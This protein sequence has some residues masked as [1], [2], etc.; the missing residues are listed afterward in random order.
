M[1]D[2]LIDRLKKD[3]EYGHETTCTRLP[4]PNPTFGCCLQLAHPDLPG[5]SFLFTFYLTYGPKD[6]TL[7]VSYAHK[8]QVEDWMLEDDREEEADE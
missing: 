6:Y 1:D 3:L 5:V 4:A 2:E 7:Y 8:E